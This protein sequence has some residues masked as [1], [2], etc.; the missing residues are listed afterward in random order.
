[1]DAERRKVKDLRS[2]LNYHKEE[3]SAGLVHCLDLACKEV[4]KK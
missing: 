2:T 1:M 3:R 4:N